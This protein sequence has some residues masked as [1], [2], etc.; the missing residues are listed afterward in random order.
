MQRK[1]GAGKYPPVRIRKVKGKDDDGDLA[2]DTSPLHDLAMVN[3]LKVLLRQGEARKAFKIFV[4]LSP[5]EISQLEINDW[6]MLLRLVRASELKKYSRRSYML[7]AFAPDSGRTNLEV[8]VDDLN[9]LKLEY[10][11]SFTHLLHSCQAHG[12]R[13]DA[14]DFLYVL[15]CAE[16][17][18][19]PETADSIWQIMKQYEV[20]PT[21][22]HY[23]LF[24]SAQIGGGVWS[25]PHLPMATRNIMPKS[26]L[27]EKK[28]SD[29]RDVAS[30]IWRQFQEDGH[31]VDK[32]FASLIL[33][34]FARSGD[35]D[36]INQ[37]VEIFWKIPLLI[38]ENNRLQPLAK[39]SLLYPDSPTLFAI[40][41]AYGMNMRLQRAMKIIEAFKTTYPA[42]KIRPIVWESLLKWAYLFVG[43][44]KKSKEMKWVI[45]S[46]FVEDTWEVIQSPPFNAEPTLGMTD[47]FVRSLIHRQIPRKAFAAI[48]EYIAKNKDF[49]STRIP[50]PIEDQDTAPFHTDSL[51]LTDK[52]VSV[53]KARAN[54]KKWVEMAILHGSRSVVRMNPEFASVIIPNMIEKYREWL[55]HGIAYE[56]RTGFVN[57]EVVNPNEL[58]YPDVVRKGWAVE[59]EWRWKR[60]ESVR[61][62]MDKDW[63]D[64]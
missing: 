27:G 51:K 15:S 49:L 29:I 17:L 8:V 38:P 21:V 34:A 62:G 28:D 1:L 37:A 64:D 10:G 36:G 54:I 53:L 60:D 46:R 33:L 22:D 2:T 23:K 42:L 3:R 26:R 47:V 14:D 31:E 63:F 24:L 19:S 58:R 11:R 12:V 61:Y 43:Q 30:S 7:R 56:A 4:Q 25:K 18:Q 5:K 16:A 35:V 50:L 57:M 13:L 44:A 48:D 41:T 6:K 52:E 32:E 20:K 9:E 39:K 55:G 40:V 59:L 45:P